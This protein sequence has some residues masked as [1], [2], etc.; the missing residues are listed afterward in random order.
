VTEEKDALR[1]LM[2][3]RR[4]ALSQA[5]K[6]SAD[7]SACAQLTARF[8][9][10][11]TVA[12]YLAS[13]GEIAIDAAVAAFLAGG[14]TVA[15]PRWTGETYALA[16]VESLSPAALRRGPMGIREPVCGEVI[17]PER[18]AVWIVPGLAFTP[19]GGRLGYGGGWYDRLLA[20]AA[21]SAAAWGVAYPFQLV[22][23]LP[24]EAHDRR[25]DGVVV[26]SLPLNLI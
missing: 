12:V 10:A 8:A 17:A 2:R 19:D 9:G 6:A 16:R 4:K 23:A 21:P 18:V 11:G 15:A 24:L 13:P 3:A 14:Q 1:A 22:E 25:L 5:Q 26:A 7:A 20:A